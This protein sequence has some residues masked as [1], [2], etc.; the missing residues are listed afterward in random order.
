MIWAFLFFSFL[1]WPVFSFYG[2][3]TAYAQAANPD[4]IGYAQN[5]IGALGYSSYKCQSIPL[6]IGRITLT[7]D[8]GQIGEVSY[9]GVNPSGNNGE[10][11]GNCMTSS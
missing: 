9:V 2:N 11:R 7:C 6:D 5:T 1:L 10:T 3:G 4:K 8:F